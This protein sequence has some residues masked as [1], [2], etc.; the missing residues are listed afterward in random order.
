M[1]NVKE[2]IDSGRAVL[3]IEFGSTRIKAV[4][5]DEDHKP[6]ASGSHEWENRLENGIWTYTLEDIWGG[7]RNCYSD[8]AADVKAKYDTEIR[9][10]K[11]I[12]FS[13][14]MHGYLAFDKE[15]NLLVPF[16]TWRNGITGEAAAA[17]TELFNYNIPQR[18]SISH[19]YQAVL[20]K[21]EHVK[22]VA[23]FTTLAGFIH[24]KL[25]GQKVLG[26]G[27]ASGMFP[28]APDTKDYDAA[29]LEKFNG[30]DAVKGFSWKLTDI[31]PKVLQ[32][33][34]DAGTLTEEGAKLLDESG[35]L[36]AGCP[37]C[38]PEGDAGT[39]MVATNSVAQR[40]GNVSAGTSIFGMIVLE[41]NLKDVYEEI[42]MVTTPD[43]S[44][45]AMVH[46]NNCTSD[47][48]AWVGIFKEC[49]ES[50][51]MKVDGNELYG[52]LYRK[53]MEGDPD[54]GGILSYGYLSGEN[55][56]RVEEG[57]P[58]VVRTPKSNFSLANFMRSHLLT[59]LGALK[60][61]M[62]ILLK[63]E[64]VKI[65]TIF[66]HGGLFKTEGVGQ[67]LLASS[68]GASV[69]V[70]ET[71]GEG[72]PWGMALLAAYAVEKAEGE[73]LQDYLNNR[74]FAGSNCIT[75]EPDEKDAAGIEV[76]IE[77]YKQGIPI[78]QAAGQYLK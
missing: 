51:G 21:E 77:R 64:N 16:R 68:I 38:P 20:N 30:L 19:L 47:L 43:G 7:L 27:D 18:W 69:S 46:A 42:D 52:T 76:F 12:G 72:G 40:T 54:C 63:K 3:G 26:V 4:L 70:M 31:L 17:L 24:W 48:N 9:S 57:R 59:A 73:S 60:V 56:T 58:M 61:G 36:Q 28:I 11:A 78:E 66:G 5:I 41:D 71:A 25:T 45:V 37:I 15:D 53:A 10:L 8:M 39:G 1:G 23:F 13:A 49:L 50:F 29:M 44:P 14:M 33:G 2:L 35:V 74:V 22:D 67:N 55:I 6:V 32:A 75:V 34:E 62:D 65:D